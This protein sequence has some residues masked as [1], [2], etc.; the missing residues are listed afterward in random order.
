MEAV[1]TEASEGGEAG[2]SAEDLD[3]NHPIVPI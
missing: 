1:G 3:E 2:F